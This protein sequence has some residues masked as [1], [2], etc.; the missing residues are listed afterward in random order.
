MVTTQS[1][2]WIAL[3]NGMT[4]DE[5][6]RYL[7]LS[8]FVNPRLRSKENTTL[9]SFP[10]FCNWAHSMQPDRATFSIEV[11]NGTQPKKV[12]P[13]YRVSPPPIQQ[14]WCSLFE[15]NIPVHPHE[16]DDYS[17]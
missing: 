1:L 3:P 17:N 12:V 15:S 5:N 4:T 16:F 2:L 10:D 9:A 13:A 11:D 6:N 8:V 14:L 7:R